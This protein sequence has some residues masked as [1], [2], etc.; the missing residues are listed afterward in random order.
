MRLLHSISARSNA[1][2]NESWRG[3][4]KHYCSCTLMFQTLS[5]KLQPCIWKW[6]F[7]ITL[8]ASLEQGIDLSPRH[9][10]PLKVETQHLKL[11][12]PPRSC[13]CISRISS[14]P[15]LANISSIL[16]SA[17][18]SRLTSGEE[19]ICCAAI[20]VFFFWLTPPFY[21]LGVPP[22]HLPFFL[23]LSLRTSISMII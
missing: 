18:H 23:P 22:P 21:F 13:T 16:V 10:R 14:A 7:K 8:T 19:I 12:Q 6:T 3:L 17:H 9:S 2:V 11:L 5:Y 1:W 20:C 4:D 15:W